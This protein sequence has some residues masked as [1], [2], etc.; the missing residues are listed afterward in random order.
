M[1]LEFERLPTEA[2]SIEPK[3]IDQ[4]IAL[5]NQIPDDSRQWQTYL[6]GLALF[7]LKKWLEERDDNL[8][9]NWQKSTISKPELANVFPIVTNLQVS[10]FRI[11]LI[12]V[13][14]IFS[15]GVYLSRLAVDLPEFIPHFYVLVEV[16]EEQDYGIVIGVIDYQKLRE[17]I[18]ASSNIDIQVD[19]T[20]KIP[21]DWFEKDPNN[22]LLYLRALKP[23]AIPLPILPTNR[24]EQLTAIEN[25]LVRLLPQLQ[26]PEI[27]LWQVLNWEQGSVVLTA[28]DLLDWVYKLQTDN[29]E[30]A[31]LGSR[32]TYLL[33]LIRLIAQPAINLGRWLWD[34]LDEI[35]ESLSWQLLNLT[36]ARQ[37]RSPVEEFAV[38]KSQL[39][40]QG[41]EIPIVARC[42]H[43]NF[44]LAG[45]PLRIYAVAWNSS[46]KNDPDTWSL[47]LILGAPAP[48]SLPHNLKFR[49]S[50]RT[51]I[52]TQQQLN[53]Q[54]F[55]SYLFTA[56]AGTWDEKFIASVS[57]AEGVEVTL[58]PF[59]FDIRQSA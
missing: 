35:G 37:F 3:D 6:N 9:V 58:P 26:A 15:D 27:E 18:T 43:H 7:T 14:S 10:Q 54:Q 40:T 24:H 33:D 59:A 36:P 49:L 5:S 1:S 32:E 31:D 57:I 46:T 16:L 20:Y 38:I 8:T 13:G 42:G 22:L 56:V 53:P 34:E 12:T 50:D 44:N 51:G 45:N 55:N 11:C 52:L 23:E 41:V 4:A 28:P 39:Q 19:W 17:N 21:L 47:L 30:T 2:L 25:E 29:L 48:N